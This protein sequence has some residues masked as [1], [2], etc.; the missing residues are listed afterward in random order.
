LRSYRR[1]SERKSFRPGVG[2]RELELHRRIEPLDAR[3]PLLDPTPRL[4]R[5]DTLAL[6]GRSGEQRFDPG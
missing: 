5:R 2:E 4:G 3:E 1:S 6:R